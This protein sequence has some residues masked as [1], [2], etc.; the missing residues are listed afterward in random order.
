MPE[1]SVIMGVYNETNENII[2]YAVDSILEQTYEDFEFIIY[3][4]G[5]CKETVDILH[6]I[7]KSDD[8]IVLIGSDNN[9]GLA[10]SL[11]ACIEVARGNFIARMDCDDYSH[12]MRLEKQLKY[13]KCHPEI[14]WCGTNAFLFD[15]N[16]IWGARKMKPTPSLNDFYKYSPYIHPS[17]MYRKSVFLTEEGYSESEDTLRCEDYEIF[18][19]LHNRGL[20]GAN[21]QENLFS[22]RE[23]DNTYAKRTWSTRIDESRLRFRMLRDMN[24]L[25]P[26]GWIS[27]IRPIMGGIIP[28]SILKRRKHRL[29][30]M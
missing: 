17:V 5:S 6:K 19:R 14:D 30:K 23:T 29:G 2:N 16:G 4:D 18:L 13:L 22:Y 3:N 27:V 26:R 12:P 21:I 20:H 28:N 9:S 7:S 10:F 24:M 8:R 15:E 1:I 25:T 11:N